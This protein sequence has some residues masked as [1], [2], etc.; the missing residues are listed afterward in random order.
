MSVVGAFVV[1]Q[2][3]LILL[4]IPRFWQRGVAVSYWKQ[5]MLVP[6]VAVRPIEPP[7]VPVVVAPEPVPVI[8]A[9]PP[10]PQES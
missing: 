3:T 2:I 9:P 1:A 7:P 6:V 10:S 4:L 8:P 5:Y